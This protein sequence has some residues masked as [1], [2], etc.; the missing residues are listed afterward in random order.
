MTQYVLL[1]NNNIAI[2]YLRKK[3]RRLS[4]VFD[5][6]G[7]IEYYIHDNAYEFIVHEIIEQM[8]SVK[9]GNIIYSRL[10]ALCSNTISIDK[11]NQLTNSQIRSCGM[12]NA[13]VSY[14]RAVNEAIL[15]NSLDLNLLSEL[16][17]EQVISEMTRIKGIGNW[18]A[19]MYL[20]FVLNR[21]DVL[22]FEDGAFLQAY[23]WLYKIKNCSPSLIKEKCAKWKPYSSIAARYLYRALDKGFTK[24]EFHLYKEI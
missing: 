6:V 7:P 2:Q 4:R 23:K 9:A 12:S 5:M 22:P 24:T 19:K 17:D 11:V 3:D 18:T 8:L 15:S 1:D 21:P 10:L 20:I 16:S 13:K 14:I